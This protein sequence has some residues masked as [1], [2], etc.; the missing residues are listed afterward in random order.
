MATRPIL[1]TG[2]AGF[3]GSNFV[4]FWLERHPDDHVVVL[5]ERRGIAVAVDGEG[6]MLGLVTSGDFTRL[7]EREADKQKKELPF[8]K[9]FQ[10]LR[11]KP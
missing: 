1:V 11:K 8:L 4:R 10:D 7:I 6:R 5:A 3:I 9:N 2:G